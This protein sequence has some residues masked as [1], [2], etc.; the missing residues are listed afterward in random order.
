MAKRPLPTR[1]NLRKIHGMDAPEEDIA[2]VEMMLYLIQACDAIR[3]IVY[4]DLKDDTGLSEGKFAPLMSLFN[5]EGPVPLTELSG[6]IGVSAPTTS[7][8]V[9]RMLQSES[10]LV[11]KIQSEAD[12]RS[13]LVR[14]TPRGEALLTRA[15]PRHFG[16]VSR[17]ARNLTGAEREAMIVLLKKLVAD[18]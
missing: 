10:P 2:G 14:L 9:T 11:E 1:E 8:M 4:G 6:R 13:A 3:E 18:R 15:L 5:A 12:A 16:R 17:F 7:I